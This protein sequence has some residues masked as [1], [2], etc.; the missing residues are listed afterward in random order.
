[1]DAPDTSLYKSPQAYEIDMEYYDAAMKRIPVPYESVFVPTSFGKTHALVMGRKNA[2]AVVLM[3]GLAANAL[4]MR[5]MF[6]ALAKDYRVY[7]PEAVGYSGKSATTR[8]PVED[9][10]KWLME[11]LDA[12]KIEKTPMV[13][14]SLGAWL[15]MGITLNSPQRVKSLVM[16]SSAGFVKSSPISLIKTIFLVSTSTF[17]SSSRNNARRFL[18]LI[19]SPKW[20]QDPEMVEVFY[21]LLRYYKSPSAL[22]RT[23]TDDELKK[24]NQPTLLLMGQY[25]QLFKAVPVIGRARKLMPGL[26]SAEIVPDVGHL[27]N[28][29]KPELV[30]SLI[31][32]FLKDN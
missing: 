22:P 15:S 12:F 17:P 1:M 7:V 20:Q 8:P 19:T 16:L 27:M 2:P 3:H 11:V 4:S 18:R 26:R 32:K 9:Y 31:L 24:I 30:N 29:E 28:I 21:R 25:D 23:L 10:T 14:I 5:S 13:G 6:P